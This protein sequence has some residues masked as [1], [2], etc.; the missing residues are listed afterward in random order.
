M[1]PPNFPDIISLINFKKDFKL[2]KFIAA[3][4]FILS[5]T[6]IFA[7]DYENSHEQHQENRAVDNEMN[8]IY[9]RE[10][11]QGIQNFDQRFWT[12]YNNAS[13]NLGNASNKVNE[14]NTFTYRHNMASL[15]PNEKNQYSALIDKERTL[16]RK[17][18]EQRDE[19]FN[20]INNGRNGGVDVS[21]YEQQMTNLMSTAKAVVKQIADR[22]Y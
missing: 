2:K 21:N 8:S 7:Y 3:A 6:S 14:T 17:W 18:I 15:N 11:H 5:T 9:S 13:D 20:L 19:L 4:F 12:L 10:N 16:V 1:V 22:P